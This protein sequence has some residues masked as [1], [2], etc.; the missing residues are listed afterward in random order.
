MFDEKELSF[1]RKKLLGPSPSQPSTILS[2]LATKNPSLSGMRPQDLID[3]I[4]S[5]QS[6]PGAEGALVSL[7]HGLD[8]ARHVI[9]HSEILS[10]ISD[11]VDVIAASNRVQ[12]YM[13]LSSKTQVD[14]ADQVK[15]FLPSWQPLGGISAAAFGMSPIG[16]NQY[17]QA[18]VKYK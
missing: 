9:S 4:R 7:Q 2:I 3:A 11:V 6:S 5:D 17:I 18:M 14:L 12:D 10:A 1:A 15:R 13:I 16:G 8:E